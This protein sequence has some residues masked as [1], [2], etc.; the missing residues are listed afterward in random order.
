MPVP[1]L[2]WR[3]E[4]QPPFLIF[5]MPS[6]LL[7]ALHRFRG[8]DAAEL[9]TSSHSQGSVSLLAQQK[10]LLGQAYFPSYTRGTHFF[11]A[12]IHLH[13]QPLQ[14]SRQALL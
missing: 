6:S 10:A 4:K 3:W 2:L 12:V 7:L 14:L 13:I 1:C 5:L 9:F 11:G 8:H